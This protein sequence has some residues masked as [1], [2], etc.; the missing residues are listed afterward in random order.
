MLT[1]LTV[2]GDGLWQMLYFSYRHKLC[3][4]DWF[5]CKS[6]SNLFSLW[7]LMSLEARRTVRV[8]LVPSLSALVVQ[9]QNE[10]CQHM[11]QFG[12][13][14]MSNS[15]WQ[16][17]FH[18]LYLNLGLIADVANLKLHQW[19]DE[20]LIIFTCTIQEISKV[21]CKK[22][23]TDTHPFITSLCCMKRAHYRK[24]CCANRIALSFAGVL[25]DRVFWK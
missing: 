7:G 10:H 12:P 11:I 13:V 24:V 6:W 2:Y 1:L 23:L 4:T 5:S 16:R 20:I 22:T 19:L 3:F 25:H 9:I 21:V 8:Y 18:R 15:L 14:L 17:L